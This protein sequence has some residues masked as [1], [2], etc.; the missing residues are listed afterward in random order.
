MYLTPG[1]LPHH[2]IINAISHW[3]QLLLL[4]TTSYSEAILHPI[5]DHMDPI[6]DHMDSFESAINSEVK[7]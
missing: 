4:A 3:Q 1:M 6:H 2:I 7:T 5:H